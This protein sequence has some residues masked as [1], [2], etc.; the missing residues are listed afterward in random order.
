[1]ALCTISNSA[2]GPGVLVT[3]IGCGSVAMA[4]N[5]VQRNAGGGVRVATTECGNPRGET[6]N[7]RLWLC[8][9][10]LQ[11]FHAPHAATQVEV[12]APLALPATKPVA[13]N[14]T[15]SG[16]G[17]GAAA[18]ATGGR[19]KGKADKGKGGGEREGDVSWIRTLAEAGCDVVVDSHSA[20]TP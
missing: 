20:D 19:P 7:A 9:N 18:G 4:A 1:M 13:S 15:G 17:K 6:G 14:P 8:T 11:S 2:P 5:R 16:G 3:G 10:Q 12:V